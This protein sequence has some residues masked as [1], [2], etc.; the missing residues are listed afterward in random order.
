M[1]ASF[2]RGGLNLLKEAVEEVLEVRCFEEPDD[3]VDWKARQDGLV[4]GPGANELPRMWQSTAST[5]GHRKARTYDSTE[6]RRRMERALARL[7][8][9][10]DEA[11]RWR[12]R[13]EHFGYDTYRAN[14]QETE[15]EVEDLERITG[16][17]T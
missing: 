5:Q 12:D 16:T 1:S 17:E 14:A 10:R 11:S 7:P 9:A 4:Q 6:C 2:S 8:W 15:A 13:W 3:L